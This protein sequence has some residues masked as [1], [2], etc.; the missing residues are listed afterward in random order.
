MKIKPFFKSV[1]LEESGAAIGRAP[2]PGAPPRLMNDLVAELWTAERFPEERFVSSEL[3]DGLPAIRVPADSRLEY[4]FV[5]SPDAQFRA[6]I[7]AAGQGELGVE[8]SVGT[9]TV[10]AEEIT[11]DPEPRTA[12]INWFE[13]DLARWSGQSVT[14][15]LATEGKVDE[16]DGLWLMP[17]IETGSSWLLTDPLPLVTNLEEA[18][19][20]F[21]NA[22]ELVGYNV[23][24]TALKGG[25]AARVT[26]YWRLLQ[27]TD[28][29]AKVFVHLIDEQGRLVAQHDGQPV[30]NAY[31]IPI[32]QSGTTI[33]DQHTLEL[34]AELPGGDY[35]IAVGMY[36]PDSLQRWRVNRPDGQ[37]IPEGRVVLTT[38]LEVAP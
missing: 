9:E 3:V 15:K 1:L 13:L 12:E 16:V 6:G 4:R 36:D 11:A 18:D 8:V 30:N 10:Y 2:L 27:Q 20:Q 14:L 28:A 26:L 31:P 17:Q 23:V 29:Y 35:T 7:G 25:E 38:T 19:A 32:W 21:G 24:P 33:V 22:V 34:P 37:T 5:V